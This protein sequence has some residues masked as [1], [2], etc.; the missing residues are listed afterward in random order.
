MSEVTLAICSRSN[1][2]S[3][4]SEAHRAASRYREEDGRPHLI[5]D[6]LSRNLMD[7]TD[8]LRILNSQG[9]DDGHAIAG[10]RGERLKVGLDTCSAAWVASRLS[11]RFKSAES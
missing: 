11:Q 8:A 9:C 1:R 4:L 2:K 3:S 7:T 6:E 5:S 10:K